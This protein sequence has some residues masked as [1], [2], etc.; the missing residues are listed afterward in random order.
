M[1]ESLARYCCCLGFIR[2]GI[3][4]FG[5]LHHRSICYFESICGS[6]SLIVNI[7]SVT[8]LGILNYRSFCLLICLLLLFN[9][10]NGKGGV[11]D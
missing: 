1:G 5:D 6:R 9:W 2:L 7:E 11:F 8:S 4:Y 3:I 10:M